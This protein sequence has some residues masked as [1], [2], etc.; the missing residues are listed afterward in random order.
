MNK[1]GHVQ[2]LVAQTDLARILVLAGHDEEAR[3][4]IAD[5]RAMAERKRS[6]VL[7]GR[8]DDLAAEA[9]ASRPIS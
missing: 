3:I 1:R 4:L 8:V 7:L 2:T 9:A 5:A 6:P